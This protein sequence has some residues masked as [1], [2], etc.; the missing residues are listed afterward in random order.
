MI[1]T[2]K[3]AKDILKSWTTPEGI[4]SNDEIIAWIDQRSETLEVVIKKIPFKQ[5]A[6]WLYDAGS[7]SIVNENRTF[8]SIAG[9]RQ[10]HGKNI[11]VEQPIL[12]QNEI[13][14]LGLLCKNINGVLHF[15]IQA[16]IEPGNIN[17]IQLSPTIQ[18]TKSNFMQKHGGAKPPYLDYFIGAVPGQIIVDQ[19]QSEQS[20]R[21]YKKRNRNIIIKMGDESKIEV[22]PGYRWMTLGQI[23][24][25][26]RYDNMVN[27]DARTVLSCIP[28]SLMTNDDMDLR[29]FFSDDALCNSVFRPPDMDAVSRIYHYI[30]DHKMFDAATI[31]KADLFTLEDWHMQDGMFVCKKPYSFRVIFCDI[32]IEGREVRRWKQPL[33]EAIGHAIFGLFCCNDI[34]VRKFLVRATPEIGCFD[35]LELGPSV[36]R[37]P[38][39]SGDDDAVSRVF[40]ERLDSDTGILFDVM[41]SEEGGRFYHEQNRNVII[42]IEKEALDLP[43]GYFWVDYGTLNMLTQVNNCLNIQLRNLLSVLEV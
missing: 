33:F 18:A 34:G 9:I 37:E 22:L 16:K 1:E 23:K 24:A 30:N 4:C 8:F 21:F 36:Q 43:E 20:S 11:V 39:Y 15:L 32:A 3:I 27:M 19:I 29:S 12:L 31:E 26:M 5:C 25:F 35:G 41:L 17:T 2:P 6:P 38:V 42:N 28:V 7:G 10:K 40:F 14:F 13:G